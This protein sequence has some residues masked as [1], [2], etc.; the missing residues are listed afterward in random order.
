MFDKI[1]R[2]VLEE[3][4]SMIKTTT[5]P[6]YKQSLENLYSAIKDVLRYW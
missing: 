6:Q 5:S 1:L 4:E 3:V 2:T